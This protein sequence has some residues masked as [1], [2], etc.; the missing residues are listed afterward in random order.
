[1][2]RAVNYALMWTLS[3]VGT[4]LNAAMLV[5]VLVGAGARWD[6][7]MLWVIAAIFVASCTVL[8]IRA[9]RA[10]RRL[11][12]SAYEACE[13]VTNRIWGEPRRREEEA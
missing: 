9:Y 1:M 11:G 7:P 4:L 2:R 6:R 12:L 3:P 8:D 10:R 5:V 13:V